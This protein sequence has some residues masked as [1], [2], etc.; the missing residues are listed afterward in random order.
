MHVRWM[1][2]VALGWVFFH[3]PWRSTDGGSLKQAYNN[4]APIV[5][6]TRENK[7]AGVENHQDSC[8]EDAILAGCMYLQS[9]QSGGQVGVTSRFSASFRR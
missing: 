4:D 6:S 2:R 3:R 9:P 5:T 1:R 8:N 7:T